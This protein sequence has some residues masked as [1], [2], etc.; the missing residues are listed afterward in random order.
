LKAEFGDRIRPYFIA[1]PTIGFLIRSDLTVNVLGL[2]LNLDLNDV[3]EST[4]YGLTFGSGLRIPVDSFSIFVEGRYT[5][6]MTDIFK[7]GTLKLGE[8]PV[9][10]EELNIEDEKFMKTR[11]FQMM[12]GLS[13]P[14]N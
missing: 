3:T 11:G 6:G 4:N 10:L 2:G 7:E 9:V 1:G 14:L 8:G 13:V 5:M 12:M